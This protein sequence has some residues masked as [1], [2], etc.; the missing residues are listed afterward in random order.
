MKTKEFS[1]TKSSIQRGDLVRRRGTPEFGCFLVTHV[2]EKTVT[3]S[4]GMGRPVTRSE[5]VFMGISGDGSVK[6]YS[7]DG[8]EVVSTSDKLHPPVRVIVN[9]MPE[10][11]IV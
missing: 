1:K 5:D 8:F 2:Y 6:E 11:T 9:V 3:W 7:R 4:V 10:A